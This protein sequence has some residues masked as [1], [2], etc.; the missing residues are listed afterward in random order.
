MFSLSCTRI[1]SQN[2]HSYGRIP[3]PALILAWNLAVTSLLQDLISFQGIWEY[4]EKE[5]LLVNAWNNTLSRGW[6]EYG[7]NPD[8]SAEHFDSWSI[9]HVGQI[10]VNGEIAMLRLVL[11]HWRPLSLRVTVYFACQSC[12]KEHA[13]AKLNKVNNHLS[14]NTISHCQIHPTHSLPIVE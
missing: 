10:N 14:S 5:V 2:I 11:T 7:T 1:N 12:C 8:Y 3:V 4:I 13:P 6:R 9:K